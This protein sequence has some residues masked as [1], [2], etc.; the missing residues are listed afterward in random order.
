MK[1]LYIV[2]GEETRITPN[3]PDDEELRMVEAGDMEILRVQIASERV[4]VFE[5]AEV[6]LVED[7]GEEVPDVEWMVA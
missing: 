6:Q 5:R 3:K 7:E 2:A 4:L 1:Y